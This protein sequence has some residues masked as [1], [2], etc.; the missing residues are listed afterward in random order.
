MKKTQITLDELKAALDGLSEVKEYRISDES[1]SSLFPPGRFDYAAMRR[2]AE[3]AEAARCR[4]Y[5]ASGDIWF[6]KQ[7]IGDE[8]RSQP[9]DLIPYRRTVLFAGQQVDTGKTPQNR[10]EE[11]LASIKV[12]DGRIFKTDDGCYVV[13][14]EKEPPCK[15]ARGWLRLAW[16]RGRP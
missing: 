11:Y 2:C 4:A 6:L 16:A 15:T 14:W 8:G 10:A 12:S 3:F 13:A 5:T 7:P 9:Y 1:F